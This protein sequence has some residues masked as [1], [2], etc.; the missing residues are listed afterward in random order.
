MNFVVAKIEHVGNHP[1][2]GAGQTIPIHLVIRCGFA[3]FLNDGNFNALNE[4]VIEKA[5]RL[6]PR[7]SQQDW[8][9]N[10]QSQVFQQE[11]L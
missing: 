1:L 5:V 6:K 9:W 11:P 7:I 2:L 10:A 4:E 8:Y 3:D